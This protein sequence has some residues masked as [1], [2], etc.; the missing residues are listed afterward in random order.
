MLANQNRKAKKMRNWFLKINNFV[1]DLSCIKTRSSQKA[2]NEKNAKQVA[3]EIQEDRV[4]NQKEFRAHSR[5]VAEK[6][7]GAIVYKTITSSLGKKRKRLVWEEES[8]WMTL[9]TLDPRVSKHLIN[10]ATGKPTKRIYLNKD[11]K[12]PL[13]RALKEVLRKGLETKLESF[14]GCYS[15]RMVRARNA[16]STHAYGLA[17]DINAKTNPLGGV[18]LM[19]RD[20]VKCFTDQGFTWGGHFSRKDGMHFSW[21]WE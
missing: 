3:Q 11:M 21:A 9:Y 1:N 8:K 4:R 15:V 17:I 16:V 2:N 19:D 13:D 6:R 18:A 10:S 14:D 5:K 12:E 7:Y 20:L